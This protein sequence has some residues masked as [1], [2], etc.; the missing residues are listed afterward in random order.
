MTDT[1]YRACHLCEAICGLKIE[2][3]DGEIVSIKGDPDDPL[4]RG[5]I[6]PKAIAL[7][8]LHEDPDRL[9]HPVRRITGADGQHRWEQISWTEALDSTAEALLKTRAE[10]TRPVEGRGFDDGH[11]E[12]TL[13]GVDPRS[14]QGI[15]FGPTSDRVHQV[16][17]VV[18][19]RSIAHH[20]PV[21]TGD[22]DLLGDLGVQDPELGF[23]RGSLVDGQRTLAG[24][25]FDQVDRDVQT[26]EPR[27]Q[28]EAQRGLADA[29]GTDEG[30]FH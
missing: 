23:E 8:D 4:S 28:V 16:G 17:V 22:G 25:F 9:R 13:I 11:L 2:T 3:R 5:H 29:V 6:C 1:H 24:D 12:Q 10:R 19:H 7:K 18:Q 26:L 20:G 14:H 21:L 27:S 30:D 15:E